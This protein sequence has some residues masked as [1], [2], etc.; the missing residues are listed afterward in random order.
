[1]ISQAAGLATAIALAFLVPMHPVLKDLIWGAI[2]GIAGLAAIALLYRALAIGVMG[3]VSP[4][5]AV[6]AAAIPVGFAAFHG[7]HLTM[8]QGFGIAMALVA[9]VTISASINANGTREFVTA[10]VREALVAGLLFGTFFILLGN[11]RP[12]AG[13]APLLAARVASVVVQLPIIIFAR[14]DVRVGRVLGLVLLCGALDMTA[15]V[16]YVLAARNGNLAIAAV[17]TSLYPASTVL[18]A[19]TVLKERL[20][21]TQLVGF[22]CALVGVVLLVR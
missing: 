12:E 16:L 22:A 8:F 14:I 6:L 21:R 13:L 4:V 5:T 10:G 19:L 20:S 18:L 2:A 7:E 3:V 9:I 17:V 15:N 11:A 1:M